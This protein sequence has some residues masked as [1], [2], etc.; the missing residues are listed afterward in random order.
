MSV[1][2]RLCVVALVALVGCIAP[3]T[4]A[5]PVDIPS[6]TP[7][8]TANSDAC[9][10]YVSPLGDDVNS[11]SLQQPWATFQHAVELAQPGDVVCLRSGN[12][13]TYE[14]HLTRSGAPDQWI[15]FRAAPDEHPVLLNP[16]TGV[17][18]QDDAVNLITLDPGVSYIRLSGLRLEGFA[19]WGI[20]LAGG[21]HDVHL[22]HLEIIGGEA[23]ARFTLG[24]SG[25]PPANGP[26]ENVI[27]E[28][29]VI[30][31]LLYTA[32]DCTPGPCDNMIFR[33]LDISGAGIASGESS[34]GADALAVER[35]SN[36]TVED[37]V[38]HDNGGD[39]IDLNSR[40]RDG[41]A[42]G[43]NVV[44][45]QV[46]RNHLQAIKLWAG[47]EMRN[48]A[49]WGQGINPVILGVWPGDFMVAN[50]TIAYN[51]WSSAFSGRDYAL[52]A[53]YPEAGQPSPQINLTLTDNIFAF[54]TGPDVGTPTGIYLGAGVTLT[55][56]SGNVFFSRD[57]CE[58][59][60]Q[61]V[62]GRDPC[63]TQDDISGGM[64]AQISGQGAGDLAIDPLFA[65]GWPD[66]NL[67]LLPSSPAAGKGVLP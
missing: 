11:G 45:N 12:F 46:Y 33:R 42:Q 18:T 5:A 30:K 62:A 29:S 22:D 51:L 10:R 7:S 32:V 2:S 16:G 59:E 67:A 1:S 4:P 28:D 37:N 57:D 64:W 19:I 54:N 3:V 49:I 35:G 13:I 17:N 41:H 34:F 56:E 60:A 27:F 43:I 65:A 26:V 20:Y 6:P 63:F 53:A 39:G 15:V 25:E 36:I 50:N 61:F 48:N 24:N 58:I 31:D 14:T 21:N 52:V 38:I 44:G 23:G 40:D 8:P 66:V 9:S 55:A 47:G